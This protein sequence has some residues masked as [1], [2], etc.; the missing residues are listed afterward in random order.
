MAVPEVI[1][2]YHIIHWDR[3]TSIINEGYLL[4][5]K[6]ISGQPQSGSVIGMNNIK[7]RRLNLPLQS[8]RGLHVGDC[9]PFYFCPRSVMLYLIHRDNYPDLPYHGGQDQIIHLEADL[10]RVTAWA[11]QN[12]RRWAFTTSNA[13]S[14]FFEDYANLKHLDKL[15]WNTIQSPNWQSHRE[16]KQ[17]EFLVEESFPWELVDRIGVRSANTASIVETITSRASHQPQITVAPNWYY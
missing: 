2:I 1:K 5:D 16:N 10:S 15:D 8:H 7:Q 13:G 11:S 4:C 6:I 3:L 12:N 9:V 17:A 14:Y